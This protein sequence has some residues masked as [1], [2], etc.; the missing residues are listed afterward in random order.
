MSTDRRA[1]YNDPEEA[2]RVVLD[3]RQSNIWT[4]LPGIVQLVDFTEMTCSIQPSI[5]GVISLED[6]TTQN[7][8]LPVLIHVPIVFPS[9]GG[10]TITM[11]LAV[12][13]E[14]LVVFSSRAIDSWWASSGIGVPV[15]SRMH[16]LSDGFC[17]PGPKSVPKVI[18]NISTTGAQIRNNAGTTYV[19]ISASGAIKLVSPTA[20]NITGNLT[21]TGDVVAGEGTIDQISLLTH[22]HIS[23]TPG[24]PTGPPLP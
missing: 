19:E 1:L 23:S 9:A 22:T 7:V 5:Q 2:M 16:D 20:I 13:D 15:E 17:I 12:N 14:V 8:N 24:N 18:P 6:G 3:G 21:V 4:A 11:P 10:F